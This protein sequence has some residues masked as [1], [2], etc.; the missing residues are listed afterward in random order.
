M[1]KIDLTGQR[2]GK[3]VVLEEGIPIINPNGQRSITWI[4]K[5]DCGNEKIIRGTSLRNGS[6]VSCGCFHK[7]Q[8]RTMMKKH[9]DAHNSRL[10]SVWMN[11]RRRCNDPKNK[12]YH[13]YGGRGIKVC[14]EWA[15]DYIAFRTWALSNGYKEDI[16]ESGRNDIT[17]DR[18]DVNGNYEPGNCRFLTCRENCLNK[19]DTMTDDE[20]YRTCPVCGK[21]FEVK[22]RAKGE[23]CS[24]ECSLKL[25]AIRNEK[26]DNYKTKCIVCGKVFRNKKSKGRDRKYC[27]SKCMGRDESPFLEFNG[28]RH[29]FVE[30]AEITGIRSNTIHARIR[31]G[32]S[33]E[34]ALKTPIQI[35]NRGDK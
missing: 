15:N 31:K 10:Y 20:R 2:F 11:M 6:T 12:N 13:S 28:E 1:K 32:W 19:R 9:G 26:K 34:R 16:K 21:K 25:K 23:S 5:C 33:V 35:K 27:S 7:E 29:R 4:C 30:W 8:V 3:L 14:D 17:I 22:Q 18:I 24:V